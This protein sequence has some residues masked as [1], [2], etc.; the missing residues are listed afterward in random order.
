MIRLRNFNFRQTRSER[1]AENAYSNFRQHVTKMLKLESV[2]L[3]LRNK[4]GKS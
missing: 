1:S 4:Y 2:I 3:R